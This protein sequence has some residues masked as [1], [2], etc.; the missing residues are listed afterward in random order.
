LPKYLALPFAAHLAIGCGSSVASGG[1]CGSGALSG[2]F[3]V[4]A[5]PYASG[6]GKYGGSAI[7]AVVGGT[8]S[9]LGGGKFENGAM[10]GSFGYLFNCM[11][12][13]IG[14]S[15]KVKTEDGGYVLTGG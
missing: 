5:A 8:A 14:C 12:H 4:A 6:F 15:G 1:K 10:T 9:V 7:S 2:G 3:S 11:Q 13:P